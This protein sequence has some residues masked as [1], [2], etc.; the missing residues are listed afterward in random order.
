MARKR[1]KKPENM[2]EVIARTKLPRG[3]QVFG[4]IEQR[5]GFNKMYVRCSDGKVR[6]GRIPGKYSRRLW[7]REGD[8]VLVEPWPVQSDKKGDIIYRYSRA[9]WAWLS[10]KNKIPEEFQ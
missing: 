10:R 5:L 9:Q 4:I 3:K 2:A 7:V 6:L 8:L 1:S